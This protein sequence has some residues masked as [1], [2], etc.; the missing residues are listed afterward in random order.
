MKIWLVR[1]TDQHG[2]KDIVRTQS[3]IG[4]QRQRTDMDTSR[5]RKDSIRKIPRTPLKEQV[6]FA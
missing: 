5:M 3:L 4:Y 1:N 2:V 6:M